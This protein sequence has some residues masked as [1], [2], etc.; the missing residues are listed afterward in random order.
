[1][2]NE[3]KD[4]AVEANRAQARPA[5]TTPKEDP[6]LNR[7]MVGER[8]LATAP[9]VTRIEIQTADPNIRIIWLTPKPQDATNPA[10][11]PNR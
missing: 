11:T 2:D 8:I 4:V 6:K 5:L 3:S 1:L 9:E 7:E 10:E